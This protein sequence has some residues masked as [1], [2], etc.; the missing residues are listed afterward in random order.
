M[1]SQHDK[2]IIVSL[3]TLVNIRVAF[4]GQLLEF[5]IRL[6]GGDHKVDQL[7]EKYECSHVKHIDSLTC[8]VEDWPPSFIHQPGNTGSYT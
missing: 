7:K 8:P 2:I 4:L 3:F 1:T 5:G 6:M